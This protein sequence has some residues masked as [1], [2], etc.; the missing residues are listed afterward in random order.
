MSR[1]RPRFGMFA[2]LALS[3]ALLGFGLRQ[4]LARDTVA[5]LL[6][7]G[8]TVLGQPIVY[9][10]SEPAK[11][12]SVIVTMLPGEETGWHRHDVPMFGLILEGEVTV[13]YGA[14]GTRIYRQGEA[15]MEAIDLAHNGRNTGTVPARILAVFMGAKDVPNTVPLPA[16][17]P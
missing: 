12:V 15:V 8:E 7:T 14:R 16:P 4:S 11:V 5:S 2:L 9:P 13:D 6:D 1:R 17:A 3:A 10:R